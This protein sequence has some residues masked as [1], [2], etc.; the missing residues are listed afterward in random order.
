HQVR[1]PLDTNGSPVSHRLRPRMHRTPRL[2]VTQSP[3]PAAESAP[4]IAL[5]SMPSPV[6]AQ[7]FAALGDN[8]DGIPPD[9]IGAVGPNH[10]MTMLNTQVGIQNRS[11][12]TISTVSLGSFWSRLGSL[13]SFDPHIV[14]D[15]FNGR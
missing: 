15:P 4:A 5:S 10:I 7:S 6:T 11:G 2:S 3:I 1:E 8:D 9:T 14:Y 13:D 12:G